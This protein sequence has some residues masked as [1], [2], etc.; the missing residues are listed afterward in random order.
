MCGRF[1][2]I[3][4]PEE[5]SERFGITIFQNL[6]PRWN[7]APN[8]GANVVT[9]KNH[10]NHFIKAHWGLPPTSKRRTLL[11]NARSETVQEKPTFSSAFSSFRCLVVA[12][13]WYEW[14]APKKPWYIQYVE[15]GVMTFGGLLFGRYDQLRFVILTT[16]ADQGLAKIHCRAPL[17]IAHKDYDTWITGK[18][19]MAAKL[20]QPASAKLFT[21]HRVG[22]DVGNVGS[23]HPTLVSPLSCNKLCELEGQQGELFA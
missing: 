17:V 23:D 4:S 7:V 3:A 20:L 18:P 1:T 19:S 21:W 2:S 14:S 13:G 16:L 5:L 6:L 22:S 11:I 10:K 9:L 12:S 8:Q 15:G